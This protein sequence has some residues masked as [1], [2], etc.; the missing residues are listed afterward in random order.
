MNSFV[1][2]FVPEWNVHGEKHSTQTSS[3]LH[4]KV[5]AGGGGVLTAT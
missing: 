1:C 3:A 2:L 5:Q 4:A